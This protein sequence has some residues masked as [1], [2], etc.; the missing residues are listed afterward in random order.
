MGTQFFTITS[1]NVSLAEEGFL[2][3]VDAVAVAQG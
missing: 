2:I 3:E 1:G